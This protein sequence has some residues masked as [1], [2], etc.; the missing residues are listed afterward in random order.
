MHRVRESD[1][2]HSTARPAVTLLPCSSARLA[3]VL[4]A[5]SAAGCNGAGQTAPGATG[6]A[7]QAAA[8]T[9]APDPSVTAAPTPA[10][11][12]AAPTPTPTR[13]QT[14]AATRPSPA[15]ANSPAMC[16]GMPG[17]WD[18]F[19]DQAASMRFGVYCA[20][21]PEGWKLSTWS[22]MEGLVI[23]VEY[24]RSADAAIVRLREGV[25]C[26]DGSCLPAGS[27]LLRPA[28]FGD[29]EGGLYMIGP[30]PGG[31]G[32]PMY[33]VVV[34]QGTS[35]AYEISGRTSVPDVMAAFAAATARVPKP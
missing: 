23:D 1:R 24:K 30:D 26:G 22:A 8:G 29:L 17:W 2:G 20:V 7:A 6:T 25:F 14:A 34:G 3:A 35:V 13:A 11:T 12:A 19:A 27:T 10:A 4:L 5:L 16:T 32:A 28:W 18:T 9:V 31:S 33:G 15:Q 21:L